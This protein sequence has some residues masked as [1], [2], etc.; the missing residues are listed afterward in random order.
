MNIRARGA[1]IG[2]VAALGI[3]GTSGLPAQASGPSAGGI[4]VACGYAGAVI[5]GTGGGTPPS[6]T[7]L[8]TAIASA[9]SYGTEAT[10]DLL[11]GTYCPVVIPAGFH[12][13]NLV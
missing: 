6:C 10:V 4:F 8:D 11:P 7:S 13:L 1:V 2:G 3:A 5:G 12:P 9:N